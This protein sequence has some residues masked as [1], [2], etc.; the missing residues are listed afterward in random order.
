[1]WPFSI[2]RPSWD[3]AAQAA[4]G[5]AAITGFPG[6]PPGK[7]GLYLGDYTGGLLG[8]IAVLAAL[9]Y[10]ERTGKGQYIDY[11]Q[12]EG[13]IR[14]M[15]WTWVYQGLTGRERGRYGNRDVS[16]CPSDIFRCKDGFVA[17]A[18]ADDEEFRGLCL[19]MERPDLI[20]DERFR[21]AEAR[22]KEDH[23]RELLQIIR[24]WAATRTREEIDALGELY[25]FGSA[26]VMGFKDHNYDPHLRAR[27]M[28]WEIDDPV[29]GRVVEVGPV[30]KMSET[31]GRLR[32]SAKPVGFDNE[33]VFV[34]MLG[35]RPSELKALEEKGVIGKWAPLLGSMPPDG[36][37]GEGTIF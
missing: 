14:T 36:W 28:V 22:L 23:A 24:D 25:R 17:I 31:P 32:W 3:L 35:L 30:V 26:P 13:L 18:A 16:F 29:Y 34:K 4:S 19:A 27:G 11:A 1:V 33:Y 2:G 6:R 37:R 15:D 8:A 21:T 12:A 7:A 5:H 20:E 10:R 9:H